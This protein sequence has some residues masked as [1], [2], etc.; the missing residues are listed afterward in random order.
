MKT[1]VQRTDAYEYVSAMEDASVD[2]IITD[3]PV[4]VPG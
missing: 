1:V 4:L 3:P 2:G